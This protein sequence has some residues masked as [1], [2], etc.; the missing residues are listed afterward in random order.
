MSPC[1]RAL[2][3]SCKCIL[4]FCSLSGTS[5]D[6][7]ELVVTGTS[8]PLHS[9]SPLLWHVWIP[10]TAAV[11]THT[12]TVVLWWQTLWLELSFSQRK[13]TMFNCFV[14]DPVSV[15]CTEIYTI[16]RLFHA[17][18]KLSLSSQS[19]KVM[20]VKTSAV[21]TCWRSMCFLQQT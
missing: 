10:S 20:K 21:T 12:K 6:L 3:A 1:N 16:D 19:H 7:E 18:R 14:V 9:P 17:G 2:S 8:P 11:A 5:D 13:F 4:G 15:L